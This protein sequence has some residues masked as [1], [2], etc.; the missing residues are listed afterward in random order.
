[1]F[2]DCKDIIQMRARVFVFDVKYTLLISSYISNST[3]PPVAI[4]F[5]HSISPSDSTP[6][7]RGVCDN[8]SLDRTQVSL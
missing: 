8:S 3:V 6:M 1:M 4:Y 2:L 5:V 7:G